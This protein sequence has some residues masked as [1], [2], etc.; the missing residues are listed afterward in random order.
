MDENGDADIPLWLTE[1]GWSDAP[2]AWGQPTATPEE[3]AAFLTRVYTGL[4]VDKIFWYNFRN[5]FDGS[6]D[7]EHNF[8]LVNND[9]TPK[10][11]YQAYAA[12]RGKCE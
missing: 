9:F 10:P 11:S 2:D 4:P 7:V 3:V 5:I 1:I 6:P 12:L 8:G